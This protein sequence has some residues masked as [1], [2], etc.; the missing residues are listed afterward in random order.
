VFECRDA[1][2]APSVHE[3]LDGDIM[4]F[5][6]GRDDDIL[7]GMTVNDLSPGF[8][9]ELRP[10]C[11]RLGCDP[12]DMLRVMY[13]ESSVSA[14]A[15]N[16]ASGASGLIQL[17]PF[18]LPSVGWAGTPQ[19]FRQLSAEAQLP[20]VERYFEPWKAY[21]LTSVNRLYQAVFLPGTLSRGSSDGT[22][23][24]ERNGF[25][26][27]AYAAN[28]SVDAGNKGY[29]TVGD[30]HAAVDRRTTGQRWT[31]IVAMFATPA[32]I[33]A[34]LGDLVRHNHVAPELAAP[35]N[36][37][38]AV[39]ARDAFELP[40]VAKA[41]RLELYLTPDSGR[42]Q[43]FDGASGNYAGQVGWDGAR[44]GCLDVSIA[45]GTLKLRGE[46]ARIQLAGC[47]GYYR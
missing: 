14:A 41:L 30:L 29:I 26:S 37:D 15:E 25:L 27:E 2:S 42:V 45:D 22:V 39:D 16:A 19:A 40:A 31:E 35:L 18:N 5:E 3:L 17:M 7:R 21:G 33:T 36:G 44:Y 38:R 4:R 6:L 9:S 1:A 23:I 46:N 34:E 28:M 47:V 43:V 24:C 20:Y 8:F 10:M 13:A 32:I 12:F 11:A